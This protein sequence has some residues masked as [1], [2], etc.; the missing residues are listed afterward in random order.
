L[1][2]QAFHSSECAVEFAKMNVDSAFRAVRS[3]LSNVSDAQALFFF[4]KAI[5]LREF[6][7]KNSESRS[8]E[9]ELQKFEKD[10]FVVASHAQGLLVTKGK[11]LGRDFFGYSQEVFEAA[12]LLAMYYSRRVQQLSF[13]AAVFARWAYRLGHA[14]AKG[15]LH[16]MHMNGDNYNASYF[17][18][19]IA[20]KSEVFDKH[21][22]KQWCKRIYMMVQKSTCQSAQKAKH[23]L[24]QLKWPKPVAALRIYLWFLK[25]RRQHPAQC[26]VKSL[27]NFT[28]LLCDAELKAPYTFCK[29]HVIAALSLVLNPDI[30]FQLLFVSALEISC[31]GFG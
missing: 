18:A 15:L 6:E 22:D 9:A 8:D 13:A 16:E 11:K 4:T 30:F 17:L 19:R 23:R 5:I 20:Q 25:K 12:D 24:L 31:G 28:V 7:F 14:D 1:F 26:M 21:H 29:L 3:H 2:E 27:R 10:V